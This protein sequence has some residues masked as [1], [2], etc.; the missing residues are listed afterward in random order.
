MVIGDTFAYGHIPKTGGD[1]VHAWLSQ[2]DGLQVDPTDEARKH[3]F[4]WHRAVRRD[5]YVLSIRRLP[6]W[7]LSYL[8]ELSNHP[9]SARHYGIPPDDTLRPEHAFLLRPDEYL[10]Q[11]QAG[12]REIG[13]W[14]RMEHLF[15]DVVRFIGEHI[16]PVTP[17]LKRRLLAAP[18]KGQRNYDHD[19]HTFFTTEQIAALYAQFP[20]W[21]A[22]EMKVY[23]G[24]HMQK[25]SSV[26][27]PPLRRMAA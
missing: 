22:V 20:V 17:G 24:L 7:A 11:H 19:I 25:R 21:A 26:R 16:R 12:G 6:D 27:R 5:L 18:T 9:D 1:A 4:F 8:H 3:Q 10:L 14:L 2:V 15:N 23:G 13:V